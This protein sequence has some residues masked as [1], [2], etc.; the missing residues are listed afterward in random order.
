MKMRTRGGRL[1][2]DLDRSLAGL[3]VQTVHLFGG[4]ATPLGTPTESE[5]AAIRREKDATRRGELEAELIRT[6][7]RRGQLEVAAGVRPCPTCGSLPNEPA[8]RDPED[9]FPHLCLDC[10]ATGHD[11]FA[12]WPGLPI[13]SNPDPD[14]P[15]SGTAYSPDDG[16]AGGTGSSA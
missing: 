15:A 10:G 12:P 16:L 13:D 7:V 14:F 11:D 6:L 2:I 4:G 9:R 3:S 8:W 1:W 5:L